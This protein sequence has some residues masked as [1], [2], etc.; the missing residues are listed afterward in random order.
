[1]LDPDQE[2]KIDSQV[3][4][5]KKYLLKNDVNWY[6]FNL[7]KREWKTQGRILQ[8]LFNKYRPKK[9]RA[10]A[11]LI[12]ANTMST[13]YCPLLFCEYSM[14]IGQELLDIQY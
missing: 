6:F 5:L 2:G 12:F 7:K 14:K 10:G 4:G 11:A 3:S 9:K 8:M 13:K 1:M